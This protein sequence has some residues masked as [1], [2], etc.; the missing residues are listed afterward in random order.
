MVNSHNTK[1]IADSNYTRVSD[2]VSEDDVQRMLGGCPEDVQRM[3]RGCPEDVQ[4]ASRGVQRI[5]RGRIGDV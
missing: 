2:D 3:S 1:K 4:R 5:S